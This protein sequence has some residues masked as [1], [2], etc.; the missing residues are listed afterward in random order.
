M[1]KELTRTVAYI[2]IAAVSIGLAFLLSPP[3]EITPQ[4]L[5]ELKVGSEFFPEFTKPADATSV[6]VVS[7]DSDSATSRRFSV[8]FE[9]GKWTIPSHFNYPADGQDRLAKTATSVKGIKR[10]E[11]ASASKQHHETFGVIDPLDKDRSELKGRG[12]RL[13][14]G[15]GADTL[16]D[17]IIGN[18]VKNRQGF[19]YVRRSNE[20]ATFVA[21]LDINLS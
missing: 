9:N 14:L 18:P 16:V 2:G 21:K 15:K 3:R 19:Y 4:Q 7:Y 5:T 12:Q 1:N 6:T 11:L 13:I 20:D 10:E 8:S 17:L